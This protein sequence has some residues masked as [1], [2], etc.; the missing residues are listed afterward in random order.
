MFYFLKGAIV[1]FLPAMGWRGDTGNGKYCW[2]VLIAPPQL[3]LLSTLLGIFPILLVAVLYSIILYRALKTVKELKKATGTWGAEVPT[4][5][6][7]RIFR[8]S[9]SYM[10]QSDINSAVTQ[11]HPQDAHYSYCCWKHNNLTPGNPISVPNR[12]EPTKWK[13]IKI[14]MFTTGCFIFT[15]MP[16]FVAATMQVYCDTD[17]YPMFCTTLKL[18]IANRLFI[19]GFANSLLNPIIYA[20]WHNGFRQSSTKIFKNTLQQIKCCRWWHGGGG[21][22][23]AN[24]SSTSNNRKITDQTSLPSASSTTIFTHI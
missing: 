2:Y 12:N 10:N 1:G 15:W 22:S 16:C 13:A 14:V 7:L 8:S 18:E 5:N 24:L 17:K 3:I 20:W 4:N 11:Q 21:N 9:S 23:N 19:L 6:S